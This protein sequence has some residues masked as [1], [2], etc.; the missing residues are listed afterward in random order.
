MSKWWQEEMGTTG[1]GLYSDPWL[2]TQATQV[3]NSLLPGQQMPKGFSKPTPESLG[4]SDEDFK[5]YITVNADGTWSTQI[6]A[7]GNL[8]AKGFMG[9]V[10]ALIDKVSTDVSTV[11]KAISGVPVVGQA[12]AAQKWLGKNLVVQPLD[13]L[14][15]G[16][17][18]LYSE[19]VSQPLTTTILQIG[20]GVQGRGGDIFSAKE[21]GES[22]GKANHISP[23]QAIANI[24]GV[25]GQSPLETTAR[26]MMAPA[27]FG[28]SMFPTSKADAKFRN[29]NYL[30]DTD[31]WRKQNGWKYAVGTGLTDAASSIFLDPTTFIGKGVG[32]ARGSLRAVKVAEGVTQGP[33][34]LGGGRTAE[35]LV[36]GKKFEDFANWG[37][38]K[39]PEEIRLAL[40]R[41]RGSRISSFRNK[42]MSAQLADVLS[43]ADNVDDWRL[44]ARFAMGDA[45]AFTQMAERSKDF[46][47]AY[48]KALDHRINIV[49][50]DDLYTKGYNALVTNGFQAKA[51]KPKIGLVSPSTGPATYINEAGKAVTLPKVPG[52][53]E[54]TPPGGRS[55]ADRIAVDQQGKLF[56]KQPYLAPAETANEDLA[57]PWTQLQF[58]G[59]EFSFQ[60][61]PLERGSIPTNYFEGLQIPGLMEWRAGIQSALQA[62]KVQLASLA[63]KDPWLARAMSDTDVAVANPLF[64]S[65]REARFAGVGRDVTRQAERR[66]VQYLG[67]KAGEGFQ[68]RLLQSGVY[69]ATV[70]FVGKMGDRLPDGVINHNAGDA[71]TKLA[72]YLKASPIPN[73]Q[74]AEI[75]KDYSRISDKG[76]SVKYIE[77]LVEPMILEN[78]GRKYN[79]DADVTQEL[80]NAYRRVSVS[81]MDK[82]RHPKQVFSAAR[83]DGQRIDK[84]IDGQNVTASPQLATQLQYTSAMPNIQAMEKFFAKNAPEI[85]RLRRAGLGT[86]DALGNVMETYNSL[87][88]L[89]TL[90]RIAYPVRNVMEETLA[91]TA[92]FGAMATVMD[93]AHGGAALLRNAP[94]FGAILDASGRTV[95]KVEVNKAL[96]PIQSMLESLTGH[97]ATLKSMSGTFASD[98]VDAGRLADRL[99]NTRAAI[100]EFKSY[101]QE[102]LNHAQRGMT[103]IGEGTFS[104]R[105]QAH[106]EAFNTE[107]AGAIPRDQITSSESW[108]TVFSRVE[109]FMKEDM[110]RSGNY[111]TL[112][113]SAPEHLSAW[114]RAVNLQL[115]QD[116]VAKAL[117]QDG[118]GESALRFLR[119]P[120]GALHRKSLGQAGRRDPAEH[121]RL[122]KAMV[123]Q[124][125]PESMREQAAK[126]GKIAANDFK[127]VPLN[128]RPPV[129]GEELKAAT[130]GNDGAFAFYD[131]LNEKWFQGLPRIA[132]D[133]L[134]WQPVYVRSHRMHYQELIDLHYATE[135]KLGR[136]AGPITMD[137]QNKLMQQADKMAR[138]TMREVLYEPS[139]TNFAH[140]VRFVSPFFSA[141]ADSMSRWGGI[142]AEQ[143]DLIGKMAKIYN[144]PVAANMVTDRGGDKVSQDGKNSHGEFVGMNDRVINFQIHPSTKNM[145]QSVS[146]MRIGMGSLNVITPGE[147]W[148]SPGFGPVVAIPADTLMRNFPASS[149]F[150]NWINPYGTAAQSTTEDIGRSLM[151]TWLENFTLDNEKDG[152]RYQDA[153][154]AAYRSQVVDYHQGERTTVPDWKEAEDSA[155]HM[156]FLNT[157]A[158]GI[159]PGKTKQMDKYQFYVDALAGLRQEDP[160][161]AND[162]FMARYGKDFKEYTDAQMFLASS[163]KNKTGVPPTVE[164]VIQ[165]EKFGDLIKAH[166]ELGGFITGDV[167]RSGEFSQWAMLNQ[168]AKGD[169]TTVTAEDRI[170]QT[171]VNAGWDA[172]V[173]ISQAIKADMIDRGLYSLSQKGAED[174]AAFKQKAVLGIASKYPEWADDYTTTDRDSVPK[175]IEALKEIVSDS[176][177]DKDP[178]RAPDIQVMR[179]YLLKREQFMGLLAQR[180]KAGGSDVLNTK[181]NQDIAKA[182]ETYRGAL[183][184]KNI[185]FGDAM[186]RYLSQDNL[187]SSIIGG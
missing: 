46:A 139:K 144:A 35:Q 107:Y 5:K 89:G 20:K 76:D 187:Q 143:P 149:K 169:R 136:E 90:L 174:L 62:Q 6:T 56:P 38:G 138:T 94:I 157:L 37:I 110:M 77:D 8:R 22:Y 106:P 168:K 158:D 3:P 184:E 4:M 27:T 114:E 58:E 173:K 13:K 49:N 50:A 92:K 176:R 115:L 154:M 171:S 153:L 9:F 125:I 67:V 137:L 151:P 118:T 10:G 98:P 44:A 26:L 161:N 83:E 166:P 86:A 31:Y 170:K 15:Q 116:P 103:R 84:T 132:S 21:W 55:P 81:E 85:G 163:T 87:F 102:L 75:V 88:K 23:G 145:P 160:K 25:V 41:G 69:G 172:F 104:Y 181:N 74:A 180:K 70:R 17:Y 182:W 100:A 177:F 167:A 131:R 164:G 155:S 135:Q 51:V 97:E 7:K 2:A 178:T 11:D 30:Y 1:Q 142:I 19:G 36:M 95:R 29:E 82:V 14:G 42:D 60:V 183:A 52:K 71:S 111:V 63:S 117:I 39:S 64:G 130:K 156:L 16:A 12:Y 59:K 91:A 105:G 141:H 119:S 175:R 45:G 18:W 122:I 61:K 53:Y 159:L 185:T 186:F 140:A 47:L 134:S 126:N 121:I 24:G 147:P 78:F 99:A 66:A 113:P 33:K 165:D 112:T 127:A 162:L 148:W 96:V 40:E 68:S 108:K 179:S 79:L 128:E 80:Y 109:S 43:K 65:M 72:A 34:I 120:E 101:E 152:Q 32:V 129:H 54:V 48:G 124:Y 93:A 133:R 146:G 123:D 28:M 73:D 57:K 150:L